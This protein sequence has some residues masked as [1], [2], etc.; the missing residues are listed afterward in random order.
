MD[1]SED[2]SKST[3]MKASVSSR[4]EDTKKAKLQWEQKAGKQKAD[5]RGA[6]AASRKG[7]LLYKDYRDH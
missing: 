5:A 2:A 4:A 3:S 6:Y 7:A 1:A